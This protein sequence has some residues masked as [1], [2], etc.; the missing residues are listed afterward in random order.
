M[1]DSRDRELTIRTAS[2][3]D[4]QAILRI[5]GPVHED[6]ARAVPT[7][8]REGA[9]PLPTEYFHELIES[10]DA[11]IFVAEDASQIIGFII[12][13]VQDAP[14]IPVIR[15]RRTVLVDLVAVD[16]S[17][18]GQRIG[19]ALMNTA[20][21]WARERGAESLDLKVY[22][23]NS[24]AIGFYERLGTQTLSRTM[25]LPLSKSSGKEDVFHG[26][27]SPDGH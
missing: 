27:E 10:P 3:D 4:H 24:L 9:A 7:R 5:A 23:F 15:P 2:S 19:T 13:K 8:F 25:S 20:T 22:E 18:R 16:A 14:A 17:R 6:H 11:E 26:S 1:Q 12:L 21:A